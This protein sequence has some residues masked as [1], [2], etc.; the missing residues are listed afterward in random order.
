VARKSIKPKIVPKQLKFDKL[1]MFDPRCTKISN[2]GQSVLLTNHEERMSDP[3]MF[4]DFEFNGE[5]GET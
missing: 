1:S 5:P 2:P 3:D 4:K